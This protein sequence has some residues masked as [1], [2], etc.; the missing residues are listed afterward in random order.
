MSRSD[1]KIEVTILNFAPVGSLKFFALQEYIEF[2]QEFPVPHFNNVYWKDLESP[3]EGFGPFPTMYL[4][5][6]HYKATIIGRR[7]T[8]PNNV[9]N[10]NFKLR[11]KV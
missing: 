9:V 10:Y 11:K 7:E 2:I 4:A 3:S 5:L 1:G 6:E 8:L